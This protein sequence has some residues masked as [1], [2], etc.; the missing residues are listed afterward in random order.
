MIYL[1]IFKWHGQ[2]DQ[3]ALFP[4]NSRILGRRF[5]SV[6][7]LLSSLSTPPTSEGWV[8]L[9]LERTLKKVLCEHKTESYVIMSRVVITSPG[10]NYSIPYNVVQKSDGSWG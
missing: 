9:Y 2:G 5:M 3:Q 4:N 8:R 1:T 7:F 6:R 10:K